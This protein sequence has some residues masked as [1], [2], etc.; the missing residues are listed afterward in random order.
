MSE[1]KPKQPEPLP[2]ETAFIGLPKKITALLEKE[3]DRGAILI[4]GAYLEEI[5]ALIVRAA[6]TSDKLGKDLLEFRSP[7][8][9][10]SSKITLSEAIGLIS[11]DESKALNAL[12]KIRNAA[13]HFDQKGRGFEVLFDSSQT[14]EQVKAFASHLN[15]GFDSEKPEHVRDVFVIAGRL[16]ATKLMIRLA[17]TPRASVAQSVK[18]FANVWREQMKDTP[19]G[20]TIAEAEELARA[21]SPE[22][23]FE[24]L[25][26]VAD[27]L[28]EH[29]TGTLEKNEQH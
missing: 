19:V 11:P 3:S 5:L 4:L 1:Q 7:A 18:D 6:C 8:G 26:M 17:L 28:K 29:V 21:G 20:K 10:F 15:L 12:R 24:L 13:A 23:L 14:V 25:Q 22:Q 27:R 16:L 9:D 2:P